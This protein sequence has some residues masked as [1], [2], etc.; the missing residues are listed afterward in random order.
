[1]SARNN[2][3]FLSL[4]RLRAGN[5]SFNAT[6]LFAIRE[7]TAKSCRGHYRHHTKGMH[8][9]GGVADRNVFTRAK[10]VRPE[11]ITG[12]VVMFGHT[13]VVVEDPLRMLRPARPVHQM[14]NLRLFIPKAPDAAAI[15]V[16]APERRIYVCLSV[17]R[18]HEFVAVRR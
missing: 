7:P 6:S 15:T 12:L 4:E 3:L 1:L 11:T 13:A 10:G 17:E 2:G 18:G 16:L 8:S 5:W 9:R 14:A